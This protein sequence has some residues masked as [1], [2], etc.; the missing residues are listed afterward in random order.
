M[1][2]FW[3]GSCQVIPAAVKMTCP[4]I[5]R[6]LGDLVETSLHQIKGIF[7]NYSVALCSHYKSRQRVVIVFPCLFAKVWSLEGC[8]ETG[9][10]SKGPSIVQ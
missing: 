1:T 4:A 5:P 3:S 10:G 8:L 2:Y 7:C 6:G 9:D